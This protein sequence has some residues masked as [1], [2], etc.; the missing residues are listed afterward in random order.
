[1]V[2]NRVILRPMTQVDEPCTN[3]S[4]KSDNRLGITSMIAC[5][6]RVFL[7]AWRVGKYQSL[8]DN[9]KFRSTDG[10]VG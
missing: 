2:H 7:F 1:M 4:I 9:F 5:C 10:D 3:K 8:H 6:I